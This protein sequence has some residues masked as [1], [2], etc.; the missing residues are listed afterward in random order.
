MLLSILQRLV[1]PASGLMLTTGL[2]WQ[3]GAASVRLRDWVSP[4]R[5]AAERPAT[6]AAARGVV[7]E[8]R[9]VTYPG[10]EVVVGTE[11]AGLIVRLPVQE[12]SVVG[13]EDPIAELNSADL[14]A[15]AEA[16]IAEAEA[17]LRFAGREVRRDQAL[18][19]KRASTPQNL[20]VNLRR[21]ETAR[22]HRTAAVASRDRYDAL[23]AKTQ[24]RAPIDGVVTARHV[25]PGETVEPRAQI[26][27]I[28]DLDRLRIEAEVDEFDTARITLG[29]PVA[30][31]A[32][33]FGAAA[34][35]GTVEEV[36]DA[37]VGRRLRPEDPGRPIDSRVL[38]VKIAMSGPTPLKLGQRVEVAIAV[39]DPTSRRDRLNRGDD[40]SYPGPGS[41][42]GTAKG[43]GSSPM[44]GVPAGRDELTGKERCGAQRGG[45]ARLTPS[46]SPPSLPRAC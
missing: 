26:V 25:Q 45:S 38:P 17:D 31:T 24:I 34:W 40:P 15:E 13:N 7:A 41:G 22:A 27:T 12:K 29:A 18:L 43:R 8:G 2:V 20:D 9:I 32:E 11:A 14:R 37:V 6:P 4:P 23:I 3:S 42:T 36:P 44:L 21:L 16:R 30:I 10:A 33:G 28:A 19:V 35:R 46:P 39:P 1:L 5:P